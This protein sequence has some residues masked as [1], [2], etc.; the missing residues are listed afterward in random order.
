MRHL[1]TL[2]ACLLAA[3][4]SGGG[5][6]K[7]VEEAAAN[8]EAGQWTA[9]F[10]VTAIRSTDKTTPALE[11]KVGDKETGGACIA[12]GSEATPPGELFA[13]PGYTCATQSSYVRNGRANVSL[14]CS[15]PGISGDIMHTLQ[16]S[17]TGT[18]FEG[19]VETITYLPG[20]G[21]FEMSRKISGRKTGASCAERAKPPIVGKTGGVSG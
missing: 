3:A 10:E 20:Q 7:K 21:D 5:E 8:M 18:T 19:T 9:D 13:G 4:C 15:R 17:Y 14:K 16:A 12:A 6:E 1:F 2:S 11:A